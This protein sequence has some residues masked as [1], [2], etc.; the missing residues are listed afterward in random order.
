MNIS[1][2]LAEKLLDYLG[3]Q[4]DPDAEQLRGQLRECLELHKSATAAIQSNNPFDRELVV[5]KKAI[6]GK[7]FPDLLS[8]HSHASDAVF[9]AIEEIRSGQRQVIGI[10]VTGDKGLGKTHLISRIRHHL[11]EEDTLFVYMDSYA[12]LNNIQ[13]EFLNTLSNSLKQPGAQEASQ[14]QELAAAFVNEALDKDH[15]PRHLVAKFA[16]VI[17]N[18]PDTIDELTDKVI[19]ARPDELDEN[20]DLVRAILWTLSPKHASYVANWMGGKTLSKQAAEI[21]GLPESPNADAFERIRQ[22]LDLISIHRTIVICF[23]S[24]DVSETNDSGLTTAQCVAHLAKDLCCHIDRGVVL[25]AIYPATLEYQVR[26]LPNAEEIM[27]RLGER[28]CELNGLDPDSVVDLVGF[29]LQ[30]FYEQQGLTPPHPLYPFNE[31]T[32][33]DLGRERPN[34]RR[35]LKWCQENWLSAL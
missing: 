8:L 24:L 2:D 30:D 9:E 31:G 6:W 10:T 21:F 13:A 1:T 3:S 28:I 32:L 35:V 5:R 19:E 17:G 11:Q 14:W 7:G 12:D 18:K 25:T 29:W 4:D 26:D 20:P 22:L 16:E 27:E 33:R 34:T 23:D 15:P